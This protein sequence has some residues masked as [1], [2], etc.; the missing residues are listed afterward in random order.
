MFYVDARIYILVLDQLPNLR[1]LWLHNVLIEDDMRISQ[2][3]SILGGR[4]FTLYRLCI[5]LHQFQ[6]KDIPEVARSLLTPFRKIEELYF[7]DCPR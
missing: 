3:I 2:L 1:D 6:D 4:D 7:R 5:N